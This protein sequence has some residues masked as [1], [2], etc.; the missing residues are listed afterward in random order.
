[1]SNNDSFIEEVT[2][3]VRREKL[4]RVYRRYG[5]IAVVAVLLIVGGAAWNEYRKA[6]ARAAA[7]GL[8][9]ALLAAGTD[10]AALGALTVEGADA[11]AVADLTQAAA[12]VEAGDRD[13]ALALLR[14]IA[15]R[16]EVAAVYRDLAE[17]KALIL[18]G[19]ALDPQ[20]RM[21]ALSRLT[22]A[23][24]PYRVMALEQLALAQVSAGE[25]DAAVATLRQILDASET[26]PGLR[27]RA[28]QMI[29]ALGED[30]S[31]S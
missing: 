16:G 9:D 10:P 28:S 15:G 3:E 26:T 24:A 31:Q 29:V 22:G 19:P 21:A 12:L 1:M 30:L 25:R 20:A 4:F 7:E 2:E 27:Q 5:W 18:E 13:G 11:Q 14:A 23:G 8:G 17:L 6:S